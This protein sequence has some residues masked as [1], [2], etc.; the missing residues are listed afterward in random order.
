MPAPTITRNLVIALV[1]PDEARDNLSPNLNALAQALGPRLG[2]HTILAVTPDKLQTQERADDTA[3]SIKIIWQHHPG[4]QAQRTLAGYRLALQLKGDLI[5]STPSSWMPSQ[6]ELHHF[7][8]QYELGA[9][10]VTGAR[11]LVSWD[12]SSNNGSHQCSNNIK[13]LSDRLNRKWA[14]LASNSKRRDPATPIRLYDSGALQVL[15]P[16][17]K[18][19]GTPPEMVLPRLERKAGFSIKEVT[20]SLPRQ[21]C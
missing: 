19:D 1:P 11:P 9:R 2:K 13:A 21:N 5:L 8:Y 18:P 4:N 15:L 6:L 10:V 12:T 16:H 3:S 17:L 14:R 20:I 7:L